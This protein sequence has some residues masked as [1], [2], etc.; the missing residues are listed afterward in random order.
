MDDHQERLLSDL[1]HFQLGVWWVATSPDLIHTAEARWQQQ[2]HAYYQR[3][4]PY[5]NQQVD[6][7]FMVPEPCR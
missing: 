6:I 3:P 7:I 2:L 1:E 5:L 4:V